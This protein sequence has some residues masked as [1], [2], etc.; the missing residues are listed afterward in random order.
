[1]G[2]SGKTKPSAAK[3]RLRRINVAGVEMLEVASLEDL[4]ELFARLEA[5]KPK[6][7]AAMKAKPK[8]KKR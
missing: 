4:K 6:R 5:P 3:S 7:K 8:T 1:M 2:A